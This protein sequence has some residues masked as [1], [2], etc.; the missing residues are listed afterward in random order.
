MTVHFRAF[1]FF[2]GVIKVVMPDSLKSG[3]L[4]SS[5]ASVR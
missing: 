5:L 3:V 1:G 2:G 4:A